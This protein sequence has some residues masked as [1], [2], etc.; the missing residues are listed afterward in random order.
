MEP[1]AGNRETERFAGSAER[2][3]Q[4]PVLA[5]VSFERDDATQVD[6]QADSGVRDVRRS[7]KA[8]SIVV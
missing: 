6:G 2:N 5:L 8:A 7:L 4:L 3:Q 1:D